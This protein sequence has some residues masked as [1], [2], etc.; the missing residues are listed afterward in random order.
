MIKQFKSDSPIKL[1][2]AV[3]VTYQIGYALMISLITFL[4]PFF[5]MGMTR[6]HNAYS[7]EA[8]VKVASYWF[9]GLESGGTITFC[10]IVTAIAMT[11]ITMTNLNKKFLSELT[12]ESNQINFV[13]KT[14]LNNEEKIYIPFEKLRFQVYTYQGKII[15]IGF[16]KGYDTI[17]SLSRGQVFWEKSAYRTMKYVLERLDEIPKE[18]I[19]LN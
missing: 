10:L 19:N 16:I 12:I 15:E 8:G 2:I 3:F 1:D 5:L 14:R 7:A 6:N 18:V 17:I 13:L 4:L 9:D 11:L